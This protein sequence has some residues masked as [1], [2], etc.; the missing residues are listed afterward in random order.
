MHLHVVYTGYV[1]EQLRKAIEFDC[2]EIPEAIQDTFGVSFCA[3]RERVI[4]LTKYFYVCS[5]H[6]DEALPTP[7][8]VDRVWHPLLERVPDHL[9]RLCVKSFGAKIL[10]LPHLDPAAYITA[11]LTVDR[12]AKHFGGSVLQEWQGR[13]DCCGKIAA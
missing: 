3:A 12:A 9:D 10:H 6:P 11:A 4:E 7:L 2:P 13:T 1:P 5:Q 8:V